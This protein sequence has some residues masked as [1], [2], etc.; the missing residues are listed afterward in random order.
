MGFAK[1]MCFRTMPIQWCAGDE[2]LVAKLENREVSKW[3]STRR[4]TRFA[5]KGSKNWDGNLGG[6][7]G[8]DVKRDLFG[9]VYRLAIV[10]REK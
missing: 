5:V 3:S 6:L 8:R 7:R 4:L 2:C 10:E 1:W 9:F